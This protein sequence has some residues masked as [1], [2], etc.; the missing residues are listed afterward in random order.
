MDASESREPGQALA[1]RFGEVLFAH[2]EVNVGRSL[3]PVV[4]SEDCRPVEPG[5]R[6]EAAVQPPT[7]LAEAWE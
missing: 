2:A 4:P 6:C 3:P 5:R 7:N 1:H